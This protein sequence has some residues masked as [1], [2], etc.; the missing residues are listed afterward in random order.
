[1]KDDVVKGVQDFFEMGIMLQEINDTLIVLNPKKEE[2]DL[3]KDFRP[4][5]LCN[6]IYKVLSKC[7]VNRLRPLLH[8]L[9]ADTKSAF[10]PSRLITGN[11]LIAFECLHAI[12]HGSNASKRYGAYKLDLTKA[13]DRVDWGS[14][15]GTL[16]RLGFHSTWIWWTME[17]VS[18]VQYSIHFNNVSL[19]PFCPTHG[20]HQGDP[21]SPNLFLFVAHGLS[22]ILQHEVNMGMLKALHVSR[23]GPGISHL[24][25]VDDT[26]LFME[27]SE[28]QAGVVD[29]A[30]RRYERC[31][32][33][34]INP[35][36]CSMMFVIDSTQESKD[37][38]M[39]ILQ[40]SNVAVEEKY[41]SLLTPK[42]RMTKKK[43]KTTKERLAKRLSTYAKRLS[44]YA[45]RFMSSGDKEV[46]IK[47]VAQAI[48]TYVMGVFKL[49][50][51]LC[52]EMEQMARYFWW[53]EEKGQ[54]KIH[55]LSWEKLLQTKCH[56]GTGFR[57]MC[58]FNQALLVRQ[59]WRL[60]QFPKSLCEDAKGKVLP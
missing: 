33:Q 42:G 48:L 9:I 8:E 18:A 49:P 40:V 51:S 57:D 23:S 60:I 27:V 47:S 34:L 52:E 36:K 55:W 16:R 14:L 28:E 26:L 21:L 5:L 45:K 15:E 2:L 11:A 56:G 31:T 54:R 6:V 24:L 32:R 37:H 19:E 22:K 38:V 43:F 17:C 39:E 53:G 59:V 29:N 25:F 4:I 44:T 35:S 7:I 12:K 58:M 30:L 3:L 10:I 1:V 50:I 46:L 20:L 13:Y 41:L